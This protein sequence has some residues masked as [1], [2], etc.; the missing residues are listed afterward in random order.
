[1]V[2]LDQDGDII[3]RIIRTRVLPELETIRE[4]DAGKI[5]REVVYL[6]LELLSKQT[7][8]QDY[9]FSQLRIWLQDESNWKA[10]VEISLQNVVCCAV[11]H[12]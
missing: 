12:L 5:R 10:D 4:E 2:D 8:E 11:Y 6:S 9:I 1:M 7:G 3:S